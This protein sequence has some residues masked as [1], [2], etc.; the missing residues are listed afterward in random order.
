MSFCSGELRAA[1][2]V[3]YWPKRDQAKKH[4]TYDGTMK[5]SL[6]KFGEHSLW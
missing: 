3:T 4:T 5:I 2:Q 6:N 1:G